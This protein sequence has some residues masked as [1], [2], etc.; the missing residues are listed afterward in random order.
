MK[1]KAPWWSWTT[2]TRRWSHRLQ[3]DTEHE[4]E[5]SKLWPNRKKRKNGARKKT[6]RESTS[7]LLRLPT[8]E[9]SSTWWAKSWRQILFQGVGSVLMDF[10]WEVRREGVTSWKVLRSET[11]ADGRLGLDNI[12]ATMIWSQ[13]DFLISY[14]L[15]MCSCLRRG[16]NRAGIE[17]KAGQG[18]VLA[19]AA[20]GGQQ[21]V[22]GRQ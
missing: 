5:Q 12:S 15:E 6:I 9:I 4:H 7:D 17:A 19:K 18:W 10:R 20:W 1:K 3:N 21:A 11:L 2:S 22:S 13:N 14:I 8:S 16:L